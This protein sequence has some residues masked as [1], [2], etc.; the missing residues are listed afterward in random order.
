MPSHLSNSDLLSIQ[1]PHYGSRSFYW[2]VKNYE[3]GTVTSF[4]TKIDA[5]LYCNTLTHATAHF[6]WYEDAFARLGIGVEPVETLAELCKQRAQ[7]LRDTYQ[8]IRLWYSGGADSHTALMSFIDNDIHLD[9]IIVDHKLDKNSN[10]VTKTCN[11]EIDLV[12]IPSLKTLANKLTKTKIT[13]NQITIHDLE[14]RY[15]HGIN[16]PLEWDMLQFGQHTSPAFFKTLLATN[17][18]NYC[19]LFGG[20]KA[21]IYKKHHAWYMYQV[22]TVIPLFMLSDHSEDF[23][24]SRNIP[25]LYLKTVYALKHYH[26]IKKSS[27]NFINKEFSQGQQYNLAIGRLPVHP[28][29]Q[30]KRSFTVNDYSEKVYAETKI[31]GYWDKLFFNNVIHT[32]EGQRW[33]KMFVAWHNDLVSSAYANFWNTDAHGNPVPAAGAKGLISKFYSLTDG[34]TYSSEQVGF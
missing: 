5:F 27:E 32:D 11:Q 13:L 25:A 23:F 31:A 14:N 29:A 10:I 18:K 8:Y 17:K 24:I 1:N 33:H 20:T 19:D 30:I 28:L 26:V 7:E 22:D 9:E 4:N 2:S 34:K 15:K 21:R 3:T 16:Q 12:T 6:H